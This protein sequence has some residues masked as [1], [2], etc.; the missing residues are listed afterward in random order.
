MKKRG[1]S[2]ISL[3]VS[4]AII[5][6]LA[7]VVSVSLTYSI[8]N[9][10][11]M[12][13]ANE[14][15]NIQNLV[16]EYIE[17][18][19]SMPTTQEALQVTPS[20]TT[21]FQAETFNDG[22]V[23][24]TVIDLQELGIKNTNYGNKQLGDDAPQKA[25]DVYAMSE[26]TGKVYYIQGVEISGK[27]YY[28]LT[29]ELRQIVE[30]N[31][32]FTIGEK[33]ITFTP[34]RLG[35]SST[36]LTVTAF[37]PSGYVVSAVE[38]DNSNIVYTSSEATEGVTY[39]FNTTNVAEAYTISITYTKN[40]TQSEVTYSAKVDKV[41]P[42]ISKDVN[43]V[44]TSTAIKGL[45]STD[46][47]SG[48]KH[49]KYA[50]GA[51]DVQDA[52]SYMHAYG[53]NLK[54]G[55]I[56]F[57]NKAV[58]TLYA[59]DKAGN[60]TVM[61]INDKKELTN[62][63]PKIRKPY[64]V[65]EGFVASKATGESTV[66]EGLVIYAG[67]DPV[68]DENVEDAR[69]NRDQYVWIPVPDIDDFVRKQKDSNGNLV[70]V[71][72]NFGYKEPFILNDTSSLTQHQLEG[73]QKEQAEYQAMRESVDKYGGFY[74][75]RY[76]AGSKKRR[77]RWHVASGTT[78]LIPSKKNVYAYNGVAWG[79]SMTDVGEDDTIIDSDGYDQGVGACYLARTVYPEEG[80]YSVVSTLVYGV[81]WDAAMEFMKDIENPNGTV[82]DYYIFDSTGMGWYGG[83]QSGNS[84]Y[85]TGK[86]VDEN[87]SNKVKNIYDMGG[88]AI[89]WT[90]EASPS[91]ARTLRGRYYPQ[92]GASYPASGRSF[93]EAGV[94]G[95]GFRIA[96]YL[97]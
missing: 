31:Q 53:K 49:F 23:N 25:K 67:T 37:V 4:I 32:N 20:D 60:Y 33:S 97:K 12:A 46:A 93:Y 43:M 81:Q 72:E 66:E 38:I 1:I 10:K 56:K 24:L 59:E 5:I 28:T 9:A 2:L 13:F 39:T 27:K 3:A 63:K 57:V 42:V 22:K 95:P 29:D 71:P 80:D 73:Y 65:P 17:R 62:V 30:K 18:E 78:E 55:S 19:E 8:S 26:S 11:K 86:D 94:C 47:L 69:L 45:N 54:S 88:N 68:T 48:I 36:A 21:Q 35:W 50:E 92:D 79:K 83:N 16:T 52:P 34:S 61:W 44:D 58:Y 75:G 91:T 87:A 70:P 74:I 84:N 64:T 6:V 7:S 14:I 15:Y 89:E 41:A 82:S 77:N 51:I 40:G 76:E 96:L 85:M 90:M